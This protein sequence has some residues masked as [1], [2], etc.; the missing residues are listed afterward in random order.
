[1][2][3]CSKCKKPHD[4]KKGCAMPA[5]KGAKLEKEA[6]APTPAPSIGTQIGWPGS[7]AP[8]T[9]SEVEGKS[10]NDLKKNEPAPVKVKSYESITAGMSFADLKKREED[11]MK[12]EEKIGSLAAHIKDVLKNIK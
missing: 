2:E 8:V 10:F 1:M 4:L 11:M 6:A 9:K 3:N 7:P 5:K 12:A